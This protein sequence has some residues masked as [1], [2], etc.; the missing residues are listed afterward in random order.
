[1]KQSLGFVLLAVTLVGAV[2]LLRPQPEPLPAGLS[3]TLT[4]GSSHTLTQMGGQPALLVFWSTDCEPCLRDLPRLAQLHQELQARG[5]NLIAVS[6]AGDPPHAV[7]ATMAQL[8]TPLP[9]ALD[10]QGEASRALDISGDLPVT[11]FIDRQG[12]I[13][14]RLSGELDLT[15]IR[16]TL[17]TL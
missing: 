2:W 17:T 13:V 9:V 15:R 6:A 11:L 8:A 3:L 7:Q 1:M 16:A 10:P 14:R 5:M 12:R 4:D